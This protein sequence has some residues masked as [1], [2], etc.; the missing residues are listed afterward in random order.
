MVNERILVHGGDRRQGLLCITEMRGGCCMWQPRGRDV[1]ERGSGK[2]A[3]GPHTW[4]SRWSL[5][6]QRN[7]AYCV[8][9]RV[10]GLSQIY[11][12]HL[13]SGHLIKFL[14]SNMRSI[15]IL[16]INICQLPGPADPKQR[17]HP[18]I[19]DVYKGPND[20]FQDRSATPRPSSMCPTNL[21]TRKFSRVRISSHV[22]RF[23]QA[24]QHNNRIKA[25]N[26]HTGILERM[27]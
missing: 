2:L 26:V 12:S 16:A 24:R 25:Q 17:Q 19:L 8:P 21:W 10:S 11:L 13:I 14:F 7:T 6:G 3:K 4:L 9:D 15:G 18:P 22:H 1:D 23:T 27:Q 20:V 5:R